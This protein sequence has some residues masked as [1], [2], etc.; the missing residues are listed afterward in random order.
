MSCFTCNSVKS[1]CRIGDLLLF[2]QQSTEWKYQHTASTEDTQ[3]SPILIN[4]VGSNCCPTQYDTVQCH[5]TS[6]CGHQALTGSLT[7]LGFGTT[8]VLCIIW[9]DG[10][11]YNW[12]HPDRGHNPLNRQSGLLLDTAVKKHNYHFSKLSHSLE[13]CQFP[14][15]WKQSQVAILS[16]MLQGVKSTESAMSKCSFVSKSLQLNPTGLSMPIWR[17]LLYIGQ[18]SRGPIYTDKWS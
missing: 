17:F 15:V 12:R 11:F 9:C 3:S 6:L 16:R 7:V 1:F 18:L 8:D 14:K 5:F 10:T 13:F 4:I 2:L